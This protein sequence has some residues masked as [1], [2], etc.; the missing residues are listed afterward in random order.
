MSDGFQN[1]IKEWVSIDNKIKHLMREVKELRNEKHDLTDV[2]LDYADNNNLENAVIK[3]SD[4]KLKFQNVKST[5]PLTY[6]FLKIC[7][8]DLIPDENKVNEML[9]YIKS[10][11]EIKTSYDIRRTY[12]KEA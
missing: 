9:K 2:I 5:S 4:G 10:K 12:S 11:R 7:L 6:T 1:N 3:I 8:L